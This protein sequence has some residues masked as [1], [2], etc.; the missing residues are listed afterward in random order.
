MR[1]LFRNSLFSIALTVAAAPRATAHPLMADPVDYPL[2]SG[3][4]RFYAPED[5]EPHI[6]NGGV[7]LLN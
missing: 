3:F 7:L 4:D 2:V 1:H 6:A 5:D